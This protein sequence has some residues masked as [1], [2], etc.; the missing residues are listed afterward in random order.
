MEWRD[1]HPFRAGRSVNGHDTF[2]I[3]LR[4]DED[5][6]IGRECKNQDCKLRYF[7]ISTLQV[8]DVKGADLS[9]DSLTFPYCGTNSHMQDLHTKEQM[10][11]LLSLVTRDA[12]RSVDKMFRN[13]ARD[14][15]RVA[16]GGLL[17]ISMDV[18]PSTLPI[19]QKYI[20]KDL[21]RR[22][23]CDECNGGYSV[24][25]IT[26]FCPWCGK[27]NFH[28]HFE[29]NVNM[30]AKLLEKVDVITA[31]DREA[32]YLHLGNCLEDCVSLFEGFLKQLYADKV[33]ELY[34]PDESEE[35]VTSIKNSF[36]NLSKS[37]GIY[38]DEF[39]VDLFNG[40]S[41]EELEFLQ[42]QFAKRHVLTHNL[43]LIDNKY[44]EQVISWQK[45]GQEVPLKKEDIEVTLDHVRKII[46]NQL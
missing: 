16:R 10:N 26:K 36:Q 42:V 38:K 23:L 4:P 35:K 1:L 25:G 29:R 31:E 34:S 5:G 14:F 22:I 2:N 40:L 43:G 30:I 17:S 32:G 27:G 12:F 33:R 28:L 46:Q 41:E 3:P 44:L 8:P 39:N 9:Q 24:F 6:M 15:N 7:K 45:S 18:K 13:I 19:I 37:S 11:Y 20:E 21:R